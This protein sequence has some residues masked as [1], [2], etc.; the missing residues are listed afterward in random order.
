MTTEKK[1]LEERRQAA[2]GNHPQRP[3]RDAVVI[4]L[5]RGVGV[6]SVT[7]LRP[8]VPV[9]TAPVD[10]TLALEFDPPPAARAEPGPGDFAVGEDL[11]RFTRRFFAAVLEVLAGVRG[12]QQL[13]GCTSETVYDDL[14]KRAAALG[15]RA[16]NERKQRPKPLLRTVHVYCP[17]PTSAE[18]NAHVSFRQRSRAIAGRLEYADGRWT[19][20]ALQFG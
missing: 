3:S 14:T 13:L 11:E 5:Y 18:I 17:S 7:V 9:A 16:V 12:P 6:A 10:G 4:P 8:V 19:C 15:L 20:V 1:S 2:W